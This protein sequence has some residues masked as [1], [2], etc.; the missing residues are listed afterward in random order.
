MGGVLVALVVPAAVVSTEPGHG[1]LPRCNRKGIT[2]V[3]LARR[4]RIFSISIFVSILF[5]FRLQYRKCF[6]VT[7]Y[8]IKSSQ[9]SEGTKKE[10]INSSVRPSAF[11]TSVQPAFSNGE[12]MHFGSSSA[13]S[14]FVFKTLR[15]FA[16][17]LGP[18]VVASLWFW[19]SH[20]SG[21]LQALHY[22]QYISAGSAQ[23][24]G[25]AITA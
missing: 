8:Y 25:Q 2:P 12:H 5:A 3:F 20:M 11:L 23:G 10:W 13:P 17:S 4:L 18:C 16:F 1:M 22:A 15:H 21:I 14:V 9:L 7:P 24:W 6:V 19:C